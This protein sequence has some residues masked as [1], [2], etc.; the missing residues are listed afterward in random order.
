MIRG[1][2][3]FAGQGCDENGSRLVRKRC[4]PPSFR[5]SIPCIP[6]LGGEESSGLLLHKVEVQLQH[7]FSLDLEKKNVSS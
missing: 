3:N 4:W 2:C 6:E 1:H 7:H 5:S